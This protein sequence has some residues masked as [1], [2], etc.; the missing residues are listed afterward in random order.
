MMWPNGAL[1][2]KPLSAAALSGAFCPLWPGGR[3]CL[4]AT[5]PPEMPWQFLEG[6]RN[7]GAEKE[8]ARR[9]RRREEKA[10]EAREA[11]L[12]SE[13]RLLAMM[14]EDGDRW[15]E[16]FAMMDEKEMLQRTEDEARRKA[17]AEESVAAEGERGCEY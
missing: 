1:G 13:A 12:L 11:R 6:L 14:G 7:A 15:K 17:K 5:P 16:E 3:C 2:L 8:K 9:Q 10:K 4:P